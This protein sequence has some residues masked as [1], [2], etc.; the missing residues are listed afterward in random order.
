MLWPFFYFFVLRMFFVAAR[1]VCLGTGSLQISR[2][3]P[4]KSAASWNARRIRIKGIY[5]VREKRSL[6]DL[7]WNIEV[8]FLSR[9]SFYAGMVFIS[10]GCLPSGVIPGRGSTATFMNLL[11][12]CGYEPSLSTTRAHTE[13]PNTRVMWRTVPVAVC[14]SLCA[15]IGG[16]LW[17]W[18]WGTRLHADR[19]EVTTTHIF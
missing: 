2:T 13:D 15:F 10:L 11:Y 5:N 19:W 12:C 1:V 7:R 6:R 9:V 18:C 3:L 17:V 16:P 4:D 14:L 8:F